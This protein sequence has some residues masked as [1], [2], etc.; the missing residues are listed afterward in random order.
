MARNVPTF[1]LASWVVQGVFDAET[2]YESV[3]G[4][5]SPQHPEGSRA[6]KQFDWTPQRKRSLGTPEELADAS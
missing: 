2:A 3:M 6:F 1:D 4:R 5:K